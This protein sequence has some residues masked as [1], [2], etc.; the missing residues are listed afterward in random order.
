MYLFP[1]GLLVL[2]QQ[3]DYETDP[4]EYTFTF[5]VEDKCT[6]TVENKTL[7]VEIL[8][9]N[10]TPVFGTTSYSMSISEA[11]V[12]GAVNESQS[13]SPRHTPLQEAR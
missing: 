7:V 5:A 3:F 4:H 1:A 9:V 10:E 12:G 11:Q 13:L 2:A 8:D 6:L